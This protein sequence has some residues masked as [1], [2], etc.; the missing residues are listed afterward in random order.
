MGAS[1]L[2]GWPPTRDP[3]AAGPAREVV[4][5]LAEQR[6]R[7][8]LFDTLGICRFVSYPDEAIVEFFEVIT[9]E[10]PRLEE[11]LE[12]PRR[13]EALARIHAVLD[14]ITPPLDD[15]IPPK[16][17]KPIEEG[18]LKGVKAF[19]DE[20]D[21]RESIREYY[22]IRGWHMDYGVPLPETLEKLGIPWAADDAKRALKVVEA[23]IK[24]ASI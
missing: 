24:A 17:M 16:W 12:V 3:P 8:A 21:M 10:R 20:Y 13:A 7:D 23:R 5:G 19:L 4:K 18:P 6:D 22:R 9:G 2:R 1:H 14:H 11:L 15:T